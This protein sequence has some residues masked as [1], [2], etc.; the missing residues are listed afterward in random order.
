MATLKD[1]AELA[2]VTVTTVSRVLNNRDNRLELHGIATPRPLAV[3]ERHVVI[4][5]YSCR[6]SRFL[7]GKNCVFSFIYHSFL[8]LS[9][10]AA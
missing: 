5:H 3:I 8:S 9:W 7:R 6:M 1:V 4:V 10:Q 2:G